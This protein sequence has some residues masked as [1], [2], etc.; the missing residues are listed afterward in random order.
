MTD[1]RCLLEWRWIVVNWCGGKDS[2]AALRA[3]VDECDRQG[4]SRD[5]IVVSHQCLGRMEWEGTRELVERQAAHYGLRVEISK[6]R[7]KN[8]NSPDLLDY[9]LK[10]GKWPSSSARWCTS[11]LKRS[12]GNR[13]LTMLSRE[14]PGP[15]LQ[16]FGFR[17]EESPARK[18]KAVFEQDKRAST[19]IK[20]VYN[21][22]P[23]HHWTEDEVWADIRESGV[24]WHPAYDLGMPRLSCCACIFAPQG[25]L[26]IAAKHNPELFA[27][28]ARVEREIG[29]DFQHK[30]P[31]AEI[32]AAVNRGEEPNLTGGAWNM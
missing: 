30:K 32:I 28:Y 31:I 13:V 26:M 29:H 11:E 9:A 23:I 24:P 14:R 1:R 4:I 25:A 7:D 12:P 10:R 15:I 16:V 20:P 19:G 22:L 6:Y 21:W 3:V 17:A 2:Q 8:G 27:E 5:R 18:K